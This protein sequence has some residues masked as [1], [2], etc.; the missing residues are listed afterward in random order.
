[1][2]SPIG[3]DRYQDMR[4]LIRLPRSSLASHFRQKVDD[5]AEVTQFPRLAAFV[6]WNL[7]PWVKSYLKYAFHRKHAFLIYPPL[8]ERGCY[9]MISAT[10]S[11][12]VRVSIAGDWGTGTE[13][14]DRIAAQPVRLR[15]RRAPKMKRSPLTP[16]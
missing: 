5:L 16:E 13:E 4:D 11:E 12:S 3:R 8:G 15:E 6:P 2:N 10:G 1:M 7:W 14:A 9:M